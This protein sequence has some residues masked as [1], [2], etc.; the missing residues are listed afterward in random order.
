MKILSKL[1]I[2]II[3]ALVFVSFWLVRK[4]AEK[5]DYYEKCASVCA[6]AIGDDFPKLKL[7]MGKCKEKFLEEDNS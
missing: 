6:S 3:I 1:I 7:C 2:I 4:E 5:Q